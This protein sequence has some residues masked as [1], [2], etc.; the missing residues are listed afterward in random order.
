MTGKEW[1]REA[2]VTIFEKGN[3]IVNQKM[4]IRIKGD[5]TRNSPGKSFNLYARK[6]YGKKKKLMQNY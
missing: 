2:S 1:E 4:G 5:S 3:I 6:Q